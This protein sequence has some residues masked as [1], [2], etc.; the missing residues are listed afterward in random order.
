M[1]DETEDDSDADPCYEESSASSQSSSDA[2]SAND[3]TSSESSCEDSN[4]KPSCIS[5]RISTTVQGS[6]GVCLVVEQLL[7]INM[8]T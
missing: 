6:V 7:F 3:E 5:L 4:G 8:L 1:A 2:D